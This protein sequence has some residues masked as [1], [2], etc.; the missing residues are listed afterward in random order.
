MPSLTNPLGYIGLLLKKTVVV[1]LLIVDILAFVVFGNQ[2]AWFIFPI[3]LIVALLI[4][5]Y[6]V[7]RDLELEKN[8]LRTELLSITNALPRVDIFINQEGI[9][10]KRIPIA[11]HHLP[12]PLDIEIMVSE[13]KDSLIKRYREGREIASPPSSRLSVKI[14]G[15]NPEEYEER[16]N[17]FIDEYKTFLANDYIH[18]VR[19]DRLISFYPLMRNDGKVPAEKITVRIHCPL[20]ARLPSDD[21]LIWFYSDSKENPPKPPKEPPISVNPL[22]RIGLGGLL[23]NYDFL[24]RPLDFVLPDLSHSNVSGPEYDRDSRT[25]EY[26]ISE[27][28]HGLDENEIDPFLIWLGDVTTRETLFLQVDIFAA[29]LPER[30]REELILDLSGSS[31]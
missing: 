26:Y 11:L 8:E 25:V 27:L 3:V 16:L 24:S 29:N 19:L 13:K 15:S 7:Y 30:L 9:L 4:G 10:R 12:E 14:V 22:S 28:I 31:S 5:S 1:A 18:R 6:F 2:L 20:P 17:K 21:E 23:G